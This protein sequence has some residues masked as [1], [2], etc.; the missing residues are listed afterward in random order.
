MT[1]HRVSAAFALLAAAC[2]APAVEPRS[3]GDTEAPG[4][5]TRTPSPGTL[6]GAW[7]LEHEVTITHERGTNAFRAVLQKRDDE[8]LLVV[9]GPQD[10]PAIEVRQEGRAMSHR[11]HGPVELPFPP[12]YMLN[13]VH[14]TWL[15]PSVAPPDG[16]GERTRAIDGERVRELWADGHLRE[17][18][19]VREDGAPAGTIRVR[20]GGP[21]L[22]PGALVTAP[23]PDAV[24]FENGWF[25][26]T[27]TIRTIR[28]TPL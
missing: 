14:R 7:A 16:R 15:V 10:R 2:G 1:A 5:P 17:R 6:P 8:L 22:S 23:P 13:D 28:W 20:Y 4:Y 26:Y 9:L 11:Y 25:G 24:T 12:E 3:T 21:G 19:F 27:A 18:S